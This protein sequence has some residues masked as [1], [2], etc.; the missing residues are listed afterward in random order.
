MLQQTQAP[1]VVE[2][3]RRFLDR[4]PTAADLAAAPAADVLAAWQGL[5]YNRRALRLREAARRIEAGGWP[6]P[7]DLA[8][9]P[10]VG[11]YTAAAVA[12]FAF[13]RQVAAPD[14]NA[15]RVLSRWLGRPLDGAALRDAAAG[16]LAGD[17]ADWNQAV[18][19]LGA[20]VCRPRDPSCG[21][22]PVAAWCA[23][24]SVYEPPRPQGHF[25]GSTREARGAVVRH[26]AGHG[27]ATAEEIARASGLPVE[28][29]AA[30][31]TA[32]AAE[33]MIDADGGLL[34]LPR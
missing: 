31:A 20:L 28:R 12:C 30:A 4:Y 34:R 5:G 18:M 15:R 29:A 11:P 32:L 10:G 24:P 9:L 26:L 8:S 22:C 17:A 21:R 1:R 3:Y 2:P 25:E 27:P 7:G 23:D 33:G 6:A 16:E 14:T 19:D 13:G